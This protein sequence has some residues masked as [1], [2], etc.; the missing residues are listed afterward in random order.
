MT[1]V[2][3]I[4][5]WCWLAFYIAIAVFIVIT[6]PTRIAQFL[7]DEAKKLSHTRF[8]WLLLAAAII[9]VSFPPLIGH[10]TSATLCGFAYGLRGFFIASTA[11][12]VGSVLVF[13][14]LRTLFGA[15]LRKWSK[16]NAKWQALEEVVRAK[17]LPLIVLIR[18]S[19]FPP[20][21]Y[22]NSLFASIDSVS[23]W[24]FAFATIFTFPK[25]LLEVFI[26]EQ[27][28]HFCCH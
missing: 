4:V 22:S 6:T 13:V 17:G 19:P 21:A 24:Q 1:A 10:T 25:L 11:S 12:L 23:L 26:G 16:T 15:R 20:W 18:I 8:G 2:L 7:Y 28:P 9:V 5:V 3:Q 27:L 14:I